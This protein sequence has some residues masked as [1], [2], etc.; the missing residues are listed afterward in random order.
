MTFGAN[1]KAGIDSIEFSQY[2]FS[3]IFSL[4]PGAKDIAGKGVAT[5]VESSPGQVNSSMF[6]RLGINR[7]YLIPGVPNTT[8]VT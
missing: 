7:F 5:I 4:Y 3:T 8:H 2:L 1:L 6:A